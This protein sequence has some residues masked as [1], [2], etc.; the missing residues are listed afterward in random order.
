M[1]SIPKLNSEK[2]EVKIAIININK[3]CN[4]TITAMVYC[5]FV[6]ILAMLLAKPVCNLCLIHA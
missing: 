4:Q 3:L 5:A 1:R 6:M 2:K